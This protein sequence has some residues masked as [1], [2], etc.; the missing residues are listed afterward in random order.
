[1]FSSK[2][3]FSIQKI[4]VDRRLTLTK[5]K[6]LVLEP[7]RNTAPLSVYTDYHIIAFFQPIIG[8]TVKLIAQARN[9][10]NIFLA[11]YNKGCHLLSKMF[12]L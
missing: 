3:C 11:I 8:D 7:E 5:T 4:S 6:T 2:H 1:M 10:R 12:R 9:N